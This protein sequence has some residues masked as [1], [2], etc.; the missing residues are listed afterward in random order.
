MVLKYFVSGDIRNALSALETG[1]GGRAG[2]IDPFRCFT[3]F[4][5][6][7][8][9]LLGAD[10]QST[11]QTTLVQPHSSDL[12]HSARIVFIGNSLIEEAGKYGILEWMMMNAWPD[13]NLTFR[14]LGWSGD[15][16]D[17][18]ARSYISQ[19][20]E[21]Y[22]LLLQQIDTLNPTLV[23]IGY[24]GVEAYEGQNGLEAFGKNLDRLIKDV[25][26][27]GA[28]SVL[29][30]TIPEFAAEKLA[31][32]GQERNEQLALYAGKIKELAHQHG[33]PFV[34][35][36]SALEAAGSKAYT[37]TGLHLN[38][39]GYYIL[40]EKI[41]EALGYTIP[42]WKLTV[43]TRGQ[44]IIGSSGMNVTVEQISRTDIDL[45]IQPN[46]K[47]VLVDG[48]NKIPQILIVRGLKKGIYELNIGGE[49]ILAASAA[50]ME[51]GVVITQGG[52]FDLAR[53]IQELFSEINDLYFWE[54]RPLNRT[55]LVG[56]RRYEQ[57]QNSYEL[58]VNSLFIDRL[59]DKIMRMNQRES[60][61]LRIKRIK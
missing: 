29:L 7:F 51:D 8:F 46:F 11:S 27:L 18:Q 42:E 59:E 57:G 14:N 58:G 52:T 37:E 4:L 20:P 10:G 32:N 24:G 16:A 15:T 30:S 9:F 3:I 22:D 41:L 43:D 48:E 2:F 17:G 19:P 38:G 45:R 44:E 60:Q 35:F 50:D 39:L 36:S 5:I 13:R 21:P 54:Y 1:K 53:E 33:K 12:P 55:Y 31:L 56:F 25:D 6:Q 61:S 26:S 49:N 47:P 28:H 23:V 40:G 34:D